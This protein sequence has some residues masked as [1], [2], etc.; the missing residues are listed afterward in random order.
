MKKLILLL[1]LPLFLF[2]AQPKFLMPDEAF[3]PT[4][5][6]NEK[7][8][9]EATVGTG[10]DIY[11]YADSIKFKIK[12][13]SG[14]SVKDFTGPKSVDHDGEIV[15]LDS[16]TFTIN[17]QKNADVTGIKTAEFQLSYQGCSEQGLC[18]ELYT[19]AFK[20]DIDSSKLPLSL[21]ASTK[22]TEDKNVKSDSKT[23]LSTTDSIAES[24]K[25]G[26]VLVVL[27]TFFG[28]GLL[29]SLTPCVFPMIPI[30]SGVIMS[31][32]EGITTKRAF[33]LSVVY[34][35]AMA[36]AY[37]IAGVLAGLFGSN[38]QAA[39][40]TPWVIYSFS[41]V[42]VALALSMFGFYE[43]KLPDSLVAKVSA[44]SKHGGYIGVAIMGFLSA[45]IVGPCVAAPLAGALVY[46][47]QTGDAMLGGGALFF[48]S[49][50]MGLPLI[51]VGVSAGKF[52]PR[53]GAW[54]NMVSAIFGV[55]MLGVA[56]WMLERIVDNSIT[57]L[58]Y[59]MLG[60]G[61]ATYLNSFDKEESHTF[62]KSM[63]VIIFIY[64]VA[65]FIGV[66]GGSTSM[67]KPLEFLKP[68]AG[69]FSATSDREH[70]KFT[71]VTSIEQLNVVLAKNKGKKILLDFTAEWCAVCKE[72]DEI[73]FADKKVK[74]KMGE[75]VL[76]KADVTE[77]N[78]AQK[79]LSK[80]Y[81]VFGPPVIMFFDEDSK[82][83][84]AKTIVGFIGPDEFLTHLSG[85]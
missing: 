33:M 31:Q 2:G 19:K 11:L 14:I 43:L 17:L 79:D 15:Y 21:S 61:F 29:L 74:A 30:I 48:M 54:M 24:I 65:L 34:V 26:N 69:S 10:K 53:P 77:N 13:G 68:Q 60:I 40:Q 27:L 71:K 42:F 18:Y 47:G 35:L 37:T 80:K 84:K 50:G 23:E 70:L 55:M 25:S 39:L 36:V 45:L 62:S 63:A 32:G 28:F 78:K 59:S 46:I 75:F 52:M 72:L 7:M 22:P 85:I 44:T 58:L 83:L 3:I 49:I 81:G 38:L 64:S 5:K 67:T 20:F 56:I 9:I 82:L 41:G 16:P 8:Q 4:A 57:M 51:A 1:C 73:T 76:V 66:L 12:D 6:L